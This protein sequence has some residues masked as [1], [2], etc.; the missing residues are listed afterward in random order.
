MRFQ[1]DPAIERPQR[2][3][4]KLAQFL[5]NHAHIILIAALTMILFCAAVLTAK[6]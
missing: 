6:M 3:W 2:W 5:E 1:E 4:Q